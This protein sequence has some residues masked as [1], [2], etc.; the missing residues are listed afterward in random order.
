MLLDLDK[1]HVELAPGHLSTESMGLGGR[2]WEAVSDEAGEAESGNGAPA[3]APAP[4]GAIGV[5][6]TAKI[7]LIVATVVVDALAPLLQEHAAKTAGFESSSM[8][9]AE[10]MSYYLGGL[11]L[12][13]VWGG[14]GGLRRCLQPARYVAFLPASAAFSTSNFLTYVA[15]R[16]LGASQFYLLAQL[17]VAILAVFL[18]VWSGVRQSVTAWLALAQLAVGMVVLVWFKARQQEADTSVACNYSGALGQ[19]GVAVAANATRRGASPGR[20]A[21][22]VAEAAANAAERSEFVSGMLALVGVVLSS[23]FG[24]I[25]LE[26]Q[27][28]SHAQ[29][30]LFIQLHQMNSF[31]AAASLIIHMAH[32]TDAAGTAE[33]MSPAALAVVLTNSSRNGTAGVA[34]A[35]ARAVATAAARHKVRGS[36]FS[37]GWIWQIATLWSCIVARGILGGSILKQLDSIAKGLIDVTA[38]VLCT[39]IQIGME[40]SESADG[41]VL[42]IQLMLLLSIVSYVVARASSPQASQGRAIKSTDRPTML[43][44]R[45]LQGSRHSP[46]V[47]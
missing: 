41:T 14:L 30:P 16:G 47:L 27:L 13:G 18:R 23:A 33:D 9:L 12:A 20:V 42:G 11:A 26:W 45:D 35:A 28:K 3:P 25:Y 44:L 21:E 37:P 46:K 38:I 36:R 43:E 10:T 2:S 29:D 31:G 24:F 22:A 7:A 4:R 19:L 40:G 8:V 1:R 32:T 6:G 15:V 39:V 17:R 5:T 34:T